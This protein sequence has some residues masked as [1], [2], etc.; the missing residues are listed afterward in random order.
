[1]QQFDSRCEYKVIAKMT[2]GDDYCAEKNNIG[3]NLNTATGARICQFKHSRNNSTNIQKHSFNQQGTRDY[4]SPLIILH[5]QVTTSEWSMLP[6]RWFV[7]L[8]D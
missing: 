2:I 3:P 4:T 6:S 1:M 7:P 5:N 8:L